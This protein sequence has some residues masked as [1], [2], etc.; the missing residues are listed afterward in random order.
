MTKARINKYQV[1]LLLGILISLIT[2]IA[3]FWF[4]DGEEVLSALKQ[5]NFIWIIPGL[6]LLFISLVTRAGAWRLILK[7]RISLQQSFLVVNAGYF[8]NTILPFRIGEITRAFLLIPAGFKFWEALPTILLERMFD[9]VFAVSLFLAALPFLLDF[10]QGI[11]YASILAS[12]V[13]I[14][15][16]LL[17]YL[18]KNQNRVLSWLEGLTLPWTKAQS[19]LVNQL[20]SVI[21]GLVI[22]TDP[23]QLVRTLVFMF[24]SWA[25]ALI[26]QYL[27]LR[28]FI[29]D[30]KLIWAVFAL[31]ALALGVSVPSSPGNIG[32]YEAS[33]TLALTAFG[34]DRSVA[35][36]YALT[37][38]VLSLV[39]TTLFGSFALV[40]EGY[41]L[42]D[43]W[44]FSKQQR[45]EEN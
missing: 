19:W 43:I 13:L 39:I 35:F 37:S 20:R 2:L 27:L 11:I 42:R 28:A 10:S 18:V 22:L 3:L 15:F 29:P 36:T 21:S 7:K 40:R 33:I 31:G 14:G 41:A 16:G 4:I 26:Y 30:A 23:G 24:L 34:V 9:I 12:M 45:K 25:I 5:M 32:L 38:H 44:Q 1:R 17:F 8:V 6:L